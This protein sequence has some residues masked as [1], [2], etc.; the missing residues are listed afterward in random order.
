MQLSMAERFRAKV[1]TDRMMC[2]SP[3]GINL[4]KCCY[5]TDKFIG[6][7]DKDGQPVF[8]IPTL[9]FHWLRWVDRGLL[10]HWMSG[11][12]LI[13]WISPVSLKT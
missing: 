8:K 7:V 6:M 4:T 1:D 11:I 3:K 12:D 2:D 13:H 5:R 9:T 10:F